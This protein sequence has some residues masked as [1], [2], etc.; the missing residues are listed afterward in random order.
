MENPF[1]KTAKENIARLPAECYS[2]L[3]SDKD[4]LIKIKAGEMGYYPIKDTA[5]D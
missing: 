5:G 3:N 2:V 4:Q 1:K